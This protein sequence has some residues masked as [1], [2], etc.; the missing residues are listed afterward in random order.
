LESAAGNKV[1]PQLIATVILNELGDIN[2]A[3]LLQDVFNADNSSVGPAQMQIKTAVEFVHVDVPAQIHTKGH[4]EVARYVSKRLQIMQVAIE[5]AA[6]E[7]KRLL[8]SMT[9]NKMLPW[10]T[11]H[12]FKPPHVVDA[13][14][15][16]VRNL[17]YQPGQIWG[18]IPT[19]RF[20][21]LC[22][23]V[24]A[25]YNSPDIVIATTPGV[26]EFIK[27]SNSS[28]TYLNGRIHGANG[29]W[30]GGEIYDA[31]LFR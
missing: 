21:S 19:E 13:F 10:Q 26:S 28:S 6:R 29:A 18:R 30:I 23:L 31:G 20:M 27:P 25:A 12:Q 3:D 9:Q 24:I 16:D 1:P 8:E 7:I 2:S 5:A 17:Y 22:D 4:K 11:Q 14:G 15:S